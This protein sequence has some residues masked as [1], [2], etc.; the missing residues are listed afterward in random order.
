MHAIIKTV[1]PFLEFY[2]TRYS[3]YIPFLEKETTKY[4]FFLHE[5]RFL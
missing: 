2:C 1:F 5:D 3:E 4:S